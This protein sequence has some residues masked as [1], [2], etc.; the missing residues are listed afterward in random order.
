MSFLSLEIESRIREFETERRRY[1]SGP[2]RA[3]YRRSWL[4]PQASGAVWHVSPPLSLSRSLA[5]S[6]ATTAM[7]D[8]VGF[9]PISRLLSL[10]GWL[11]HQSLVCSIPTVRQGSRPTRAPARV[12]VHVGGALIQGRKGFQDFICLKICRSI[13]CSH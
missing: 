13:N 11:V 2:L 7:N 3:R 10:V 6:A 8:V 9:P 12:H 4:G 1:Q 5:L